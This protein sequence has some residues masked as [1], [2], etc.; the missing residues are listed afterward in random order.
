[1][2]E[3]RCADLAEVWAE[4]LAIRGPRAAKGDGEELFELMVTAAQ[5]GQVP[6]PWL[7][8]LFAERW[9]AFRDFHV[10]TLDEAFDVVRP[11]NLKLEA[12]RRET[13]H[14]FEVLFRNDELFAAGVK[15]AERYELIASER[16][17]LSA[18]VVKKYIDKATKR[19]GYWVGCTLENQTRGGAAVTKTQNK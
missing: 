17:G 14:L 15:V 7:V 13:E 12:K 19:H 9:R 16:P 4:A 6:P 2:N 1:M 3:E 11:K 8:D 5:L 10:R 18:S